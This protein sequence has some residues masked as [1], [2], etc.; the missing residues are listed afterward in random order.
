MLWDPMTTRWRPVQNEYNLKA[1]PW[2]GG[3]GIELDDE[4]LYVPSLICWIYRGH[5][6]ELAQHI[7]DLHNAT[8]KCE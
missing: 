5:P 7:C 8:L 2:H 3:Q 4:R 6:E 1:A